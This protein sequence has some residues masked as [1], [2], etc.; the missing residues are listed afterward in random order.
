M[1]T[2][3]AMKVSIAAVVTVLAAAWASADLPPKNAKPLSEPAR[4]DSSE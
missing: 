3:K 1:H 2:V 4:W